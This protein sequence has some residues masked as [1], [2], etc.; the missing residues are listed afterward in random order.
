MINKSKIFYGVCTTNKDGSG[1]KIV[2][3]Y[4]FR[5][6]AIYDDRVIYGTGKVVKIKVERCVSK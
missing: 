4:T 3:V 1:R 6:D 2:A 5:G